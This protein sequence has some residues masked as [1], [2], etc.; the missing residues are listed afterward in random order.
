[1][2]M[3]IDFIVR[4]R[5]ALSVTCGDSSPKGRAKRAAPRYI[6]GRNLPL[7]WRWLAGLAPGSAD[8]PMAKYHSKER[9]MRFD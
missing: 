9:G 2:T 3:P 8:A 5:L 4:K 6:E 7:R 1:M